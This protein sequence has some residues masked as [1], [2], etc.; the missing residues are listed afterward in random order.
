MIFLL[1]YILFIFQ[2]QGRATKNVAVWHVFFFFFPHHA[3][4]VLWNM[5]S[6]PEMHL[7]QLQGSNRNP[8]LHPDLGL[9]LVARRL[10][11]RT[12]CTAMLCSHS[13]PEKPRVLCRRC[14]RSSQPWRRKNQPFAWQSLDPRCLRSLCCSANSRW[15]CGEAGEEGLYSCWSDHMRFLLCQI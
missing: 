2:C 12:N 9:N 14:V 5:T 4:H 1:F 8:C 7:V 11:L 10:L 13:C 6:P 15:S 3:T